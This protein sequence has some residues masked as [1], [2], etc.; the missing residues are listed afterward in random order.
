[1]KTDDIK[2]DTLITSFRLTHLKLTDRGSLLIYTMD[3]W[4]ASHIF[5]KFFHFFQPLCYHV[6]MFAEA[7]LCRP[8]FHLMCR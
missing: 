7:R 2:F 5:Q 8:D 4:V 1:M 3:R 6:Y